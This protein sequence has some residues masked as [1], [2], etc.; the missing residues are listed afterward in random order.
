VQE[1]TLGGQFPTATVEQWQALVAKVLARSGI[2]APDVATAVAT[3]TSHTA[4]HLEIAPLYTADCA[5]PPTGLPGAAPF[6]RG[7]A[8]AGDLT[9]WDVRARIA[10]PD[11]ELAAE[12][13]IE[14]LAGGATS[15]WLGV[16]TGAIAVAQLPAVLADVLLDVAGVSLDAGAE[17]TAAA[18]QLLTMAV[19]RGFD[20]HAVSGCLG[21]DPV[22]TL[23]RTGDD[24][25]AAE[26]TAAVSRLAPRVALSWPKLRTVAVDGLVHHDAGAGDAQELGLALAAGVAALRTLTEAGLDLRGAL[27]ALEFRLAAT[28]DQFATIAKLRAARRTWARVAQVCGESGPDAGQ[29]QHVV[30]SW[31]M[32]TRHDPWNNMLRATLAC[33]GACVGGADAIT[34]RPFD[35]ALGRS[36]PLARR[37]ARNTPTLLVEESHC[38]AVL[39][40]AGGAW[41]VESLTEAMAQAAW[42]VF[43]EVEAAGGIVAALG[44][45]WV[46]DRIGAAREARIAALEAGTESII[47]VTTYPI[48]DEKLLDRAQLPEPPGGGLPRIRWEAEL[49]KGRAQ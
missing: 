43:T 45:G 9:G 3:L 31:P 33:F 6:T 23:A 40:P 28:A 49:A 16:G 4:D 48:T 25:A 36:D 32:T 46:A 20:G 17:G 12:Q 8:A 7:R 1:L 5:L 18:E 27:A 34:V 42:Q 41:Y 35:A 13:I 22:G 11:P 2:D 39:D 37:I 24:A 19:S 14:D 26:L 10:D 38:T 47:G 30:T 21:L 15:L 44:S 29:R